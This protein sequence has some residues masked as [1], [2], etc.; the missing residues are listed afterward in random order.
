MGRWS[1]VQSGR[2]DLVA[3][4]EDESG[5]GWKLFRI[6]AEHDEGNEYLFL[7]R[8][9]LEPSEGKPGRILHGAHGNIVDAV[10]CCVEWMGS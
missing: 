5:R 10:K 8:L 6:I 2:I 4:D 3:E 1:D 9:R 7:T